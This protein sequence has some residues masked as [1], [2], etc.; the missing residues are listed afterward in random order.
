MPIALDHVFVCCDP[1]APEAKALLDIGLIEGTGNVHHGQGTSNRRF[2]FQGGFIELLWVS[3][4]SQAQS[5]LTMPTRLWSRW[6]GRRQGNCPFGI[7][8][9]PT[10]LDVAEP[11]FLGWAYKPG[12]LP[13]GKEIWF[14]SDTTL[15]EPELVYLAWPNPQASAAAQ[16]KKHKEQ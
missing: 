10:G 4:S 16:P 3:D 7:A 9:S 8:Y 6:L 14:A 2:F 13:S 12:Y 11:P 5:A 1:G 15:K